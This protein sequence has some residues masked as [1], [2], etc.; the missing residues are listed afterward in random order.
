M[1]CLHDQINNKR[2]A[3]RICVFCLTLLLSLQFCHWL[4]D[5]LVNCKYALTLPLPIPRLNAMFHAHNV[6]IFSYYQGALAFL[7]ESFRSENWCMK[8]LIIVDHNV[9]KLAYK[10][11]Q[12]QNFSGGYTS[13]L[14]VNRG[15]GKRIEE[16]K[17]GE[18]EWGR[19]RVRDGES[20]RGRK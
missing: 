1:A 14:L 19:G 9:L 3:D 12:F 4:S 13:E 8:G 11:L 10:H 6:K 2:N 20:G 15:R 7:R 16:R 18:E 17:E 5:S